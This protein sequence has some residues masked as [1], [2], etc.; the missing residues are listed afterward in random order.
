MPRR[1]CTVIPEVWV[2]GEGHEDLK[3]PVGELK[4]NFGWESLAATGKF[5][6][7]F[8]LFF[9]FQTSTVPTSESIFK[10]NIEWDAFSLT[11]FCM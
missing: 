1:T 5:C 8:C 7:S 11:A 10:V 6:Q 9:P 4:Q 2:E 3:G